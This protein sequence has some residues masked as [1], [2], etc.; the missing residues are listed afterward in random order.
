MYIILFGAATKA[1]IPIYGDAVAVSIAAATAT[2]TPITTAPI[3]ALF[4][5]V[6]QRRAPMIGDMGAKP[7]IG[8]CMAIGALSAPSHN[9]HHPSYH[10]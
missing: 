7:F 3:Q 4:A 5:G 2:A 10:R 8:I 6:A 9:I 1:A